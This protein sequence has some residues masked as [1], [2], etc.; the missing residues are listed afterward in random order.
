MLIWTR[1]P[2][3]SLI[4]FFFVVENLA[5]ATLRQNSSIWLLLLVSVMTLAS[6]TRITISLRRCL[7]LL[8][9][10]ESHSSWPFWLWLVEETVWINLNIFFVVSE[11]ISRLGYILREVNKNSIWIFVLGAFLR[12]IV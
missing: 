7:R 11:A 5:L 3:V 8:I 6:L 10:L 4:L 9:F 1:S 12:F 2:T